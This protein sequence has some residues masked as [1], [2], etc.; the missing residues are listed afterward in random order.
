LGGKYYP[1]GRCIS[2]GLLGCYACI[3]FI[4]IIFLEG[5]V[6]KKNLFIFVLLA[7]ISFVGLASAPVFAADSP[8]ATSVLETIQLNQ[9][10]A[11][12]LQALPGVGPSL[13]ER[14]VAYRTEHGPFK[15]IDQL[16]EVKGIGDKK[17]AKLRDHLALN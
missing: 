12:E 5:F 4:L 8:A 16:A 1:G 17:L 10:T 6:M 11:E 15:S 9:A 2:G 13:S 14:I 3:G 7:M